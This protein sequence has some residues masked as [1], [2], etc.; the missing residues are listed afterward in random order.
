M[1]LAGEPLIAEFCEELAAVAAASADGF[2][3]LRGERLSSHVDPVSEMQVLWR[4]RHALPG[5]DRCEVRW[6]RQAY[7]YELHWLGD[8]LQAHEREFRVVAELL[9]YNANRVRL[10]FSVIGFQEP[11]LD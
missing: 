1:S 10:S 11:S 4:C 9:T 5:A 8:D 2:A 6:A 7:T 3:A